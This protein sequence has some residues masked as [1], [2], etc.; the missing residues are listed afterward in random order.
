MSYK[1]FGDLGKKDETKLDEEK[2]GESEKLELEEETDE[3]LEESDESS[4]DDKD[5][6]LN[7]DV[8]EN[9]NPCVNSYYDPHRVEFTYIHDDEALVAVRKG[10]CFRC[11]AY[12]PVLYTNIYGNYNCS[13]IC[14]RCISDMFN[15]ARN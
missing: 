12:R 8:V 7:V 1:T 15:D 2:R 6:P 9:H 4:D 11:S 5:E 13:Q 10:V 14:E 3:E